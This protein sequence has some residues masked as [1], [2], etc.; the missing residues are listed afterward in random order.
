MLLQIDH[1]SKSFGS[2]KVLDNLNLTLSENQIVGLLGPNGSGKSTLIRCINDLLMVDQGT[3]RLED[4]PLG[5]FN[6]EDISYLP[7]RSALPTH[8]KVKEALA[9]YASFY[10]NFDLQKAHKLL[11][12]F[13]LDENAEIKA[14]SKGMQEKLQLALVM[15]RKAKLYILDEPLGGVDPAAR[16]RILSAILTNFEDGASMIISTHLIAE[17]EPI[18]D[19]AIFL[20]NGKILV[21]E[22]ADLLRAQHQKSLDLYFREVYTQ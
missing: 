8:W 3:I 1:L 18:L 14:M 19:R 16:D 11:Q 17:I 9:F 22:E 4:K 15:A 12:E 21:N 13:D 10:S 7:E 6:K 20:K 5:S 2:K